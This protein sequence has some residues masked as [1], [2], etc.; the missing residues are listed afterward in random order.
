MMSIPSKGEVINPD[1]SIVVR[2]ILPSG[3]RTIAGKRDFVIEEVHHLMYLESD[4]GES[5]VEVV[6]VSAQPKPLSSGDNT[7]ENT[8]T[9]TI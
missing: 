6:N 9:H 2:L 8:H 3:V 4:L 5:Y 7:N 1:E